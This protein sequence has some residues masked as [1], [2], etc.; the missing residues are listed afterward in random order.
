MEKSRVGLNKTIVTSLLVVME[1]IERMCSP[2]GTET[3]GQDSDRKPRCA[4][5]MEEAGKEEE[6]DLLK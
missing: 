1:A 6:K 3:V 2:R 4:E 5:K